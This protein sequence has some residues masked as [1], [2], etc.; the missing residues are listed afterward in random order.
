M[1][2]IVPG[3]QTFQWGLQRMGLFAGKQGTPRLLLAEK[4]ERAADDNEQLSMQ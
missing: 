2:V 1:R 4:A 3:E